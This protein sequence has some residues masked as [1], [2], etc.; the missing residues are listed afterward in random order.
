MQVDPV[1]HKF[2]PPG[3]KRLKVKC[4][5]LVSKFAFKFNLN[6]YNAAVHAWCATGNDRPDAAEKLVQRMIHDGARQGLA[7]VPSSAQLE[8]FC[9]PY[10]ST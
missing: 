6:H 4:D 1:K 3:T 7:L 9:P 8:L 10:N 5:E 2:K